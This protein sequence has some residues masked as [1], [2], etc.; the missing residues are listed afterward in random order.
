ML[1]DLMAGRYSVNY[2]N[3]QSRG[4]P[5]A[6]GFY[7]CDELQEGAAYSR[8][9]KR[10]LYRGLCVIQAKLGWENL[11]G[12]YVDVSEAG[13]HPGSAFRQLKADLNAGYFR[14][15]LVACPWA[16]FGKSLIYKKFK[17]LSQGIKGFELVGIEGCNFPEDGIF[18]V[19][20]PVVVK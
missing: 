20:E 12:V 10:H 2:I 16:L 7:V 3:M 15:V 17:K 11:V 9:A 8:Q 1:S 19:P 6:F 13:N 4:L 5:A 18:A 14:R